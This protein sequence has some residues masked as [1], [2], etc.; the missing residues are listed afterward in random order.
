MP[1]A[2]WIDL[3]PTTSV[4]LS[5]WL[6]V[7]SRTWGMLSK[8]AGVTGGGGGSRRNEQYY[9]PI[10]LHG[11]I[12]CHSASSHTCGIALSLG[13]VCGWEKLDRCIIYC[14]C[15]TWKTTFV[16]ACEGN[17]R[18][19]LYLRWWE[20]LSL[21]YKC[22]SIEWFENKKTN[23]FVLF[24]GA[25]AFDGKNKSWLEGLFF[26]GTYA[27]KSGCG[28]MKHTHTSCLKTWK[29]NCQGGCSWPKRMTGI[30]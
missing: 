6:S 7:H 12:S 1:S 25:A 8:A 16:C 20:E 14:R 22:L 19:V 18:V 26:L 23:S 10:Q 29:D 27:F 3:R 13:S 24:R 4:C 9:Y 21:E 5:T 30:L 11:Y 2:H 28:S 15:I 17:V